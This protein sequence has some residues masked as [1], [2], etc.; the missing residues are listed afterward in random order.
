MAEQPTCEDDGSWQCDHCEE[1]WDREYHPDF[2][3]CVPAC[4]EGE[5]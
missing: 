3:E 1:L 2:C 5:N 4:K